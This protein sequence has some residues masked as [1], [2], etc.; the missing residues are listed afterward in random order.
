MVSYRARYETNTAFE[1]P[2][3]HMMLIKMVDVSPFKP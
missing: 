1:D 3:A 2:A